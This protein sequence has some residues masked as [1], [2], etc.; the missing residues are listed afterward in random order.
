M[1]ILR[2]V[3]AIMDHKIEHLLYFAK[4][5][6]KQYLF[7]HFQGFSPTPRGF[8]ISFGEQTSVPNLSHVVS[9]TRFTSAPLP[10]CQVLGV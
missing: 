2:A 4:S 5:H 1:S 6:L 9:L 8:Y 10:S 7:L 3:V